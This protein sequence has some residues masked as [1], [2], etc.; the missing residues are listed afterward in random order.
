MEDKVDGL[1]P[2]IGLLSLM[3]GAGG[4]CWRFQLSG[5]NSDHTVKVTD[6]DL[7]RLYEAS[8]RGII[9][10]AYCDG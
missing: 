5:A 10:L 6:L 4:G 8:R 9:I 2:D 3:A 1:F 7:A